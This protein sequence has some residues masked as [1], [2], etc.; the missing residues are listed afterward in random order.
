[1]EFNLLHKNRVENGKLSIFGQFWEARV[2]QIFSQPSSDG[3]WPSDRLSQVNV[4][5]TAEVLGD[6]DAVEVLADLAVMDGRDVEEKDETDEDEHGGDEADP[7]EDQL[8]SPVVDPEGDKGHDGVGDEETKDETKEVG[9]VIDPGQKA[10]QK[11]N[12]RDAHQLQDRHLGV[13]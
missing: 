8:S 4:L 3:G 11:E 12:S 7:E 1:M 6:G 2:K 10:C 5:L 13:L 9:V